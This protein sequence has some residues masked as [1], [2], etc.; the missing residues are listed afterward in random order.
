MVMNQR[1]A[2]RRTIKAE[3]GAKENQSE[4]KKM[5][6]EMEKER[7]HTERYQVERIS[8]LFKASRGS[9]VRRD[10]LGLSEIIFG[11]NGRDWILT[12]FPLAVLFLLYGPAVFPNGFVRV[13]HNN[14]R[15]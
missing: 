2:L 13:R 12:K 10:V 6:N 4:E 7:R 5:K 8:R 11:I 15:L 1:Q 3:R 9:R 14:A